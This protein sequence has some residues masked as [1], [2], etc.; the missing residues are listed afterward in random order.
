M[1]KYNWLSVIEEKELKE[2][3]IGFVFPKGIP[4][5]LIRKAVR[6]GVPL[7]RHKH[8][9]ECH[10]QGCLH[11]GHQLKAAVPRYSDFWGLGC[12]CFAF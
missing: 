5:L 3:S 12:D 10:T 1:T 9:S 11:A 2:N 8:T 4:V 7:P 6:A